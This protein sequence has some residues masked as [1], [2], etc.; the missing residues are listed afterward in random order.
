MRA[1]LAIEPKTES[2][3]PS[4]LETPPITDRLVS[5]FEPIRFMTWVFHFSKTSGCASSV[6]SFSTSFLRKSTRSTFSVSLIICARTWSGSIFSGRTLTVTTPNP[7]RTSTKPRA[8][9]RT[10][11]L[12]ARPM[13][14]FVFSSSVSGGGSGLVCFR[15]NPL[16]ASITNTT[17]LTNNNFAK[18]KKRAINPPSRKLCVYL[19]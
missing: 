7:P 2:T 3:T 10:V 17:G 13:A 19:C 6:W 8:T 11:A 15:N 4:A 16:T 18:L 12:H 9:V 14:T 5:S 1:K